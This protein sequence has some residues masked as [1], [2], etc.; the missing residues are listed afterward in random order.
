MYSNVVQAHQ[1][2]WADRAEPVWSRLQWLWENQASPGL[3][4][5]GDRNAP[6]AMP[7]SFSQW[8]R[9]R[10]WVNPAH[11]TPDYR[12]AAEMLL[13][14]LDMLTYLEQSQQSPTLVIGAGI[15]ETWLSKPM[16]VKG[17]LIKDRLIDW[18]WDGT[19][20]NVKIYGKPIKVKLGSNFPIKTVINTETITTKL[21]K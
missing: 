2:L 15:P 11:I 17:Q 19:Q 18:S 1:W 7:K 8:N 3:F 20:M 13:L 5:W 9:F 14:Q 16:K 21:K 10:G 12:T 4:T 6:E